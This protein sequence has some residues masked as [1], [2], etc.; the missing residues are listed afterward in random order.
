MKPRA[1]TGRP[2]LPCA[3]LTSRLETRVME[4]MGS[5]TPWATVLA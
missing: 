2:A 3:L 4:C 5:A 1:V